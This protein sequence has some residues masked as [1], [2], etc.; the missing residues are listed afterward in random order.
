MIELRGGW[1]CVRERIYLYRNYNQMFDK[2]KTMIVQ[3]FILCLVEIAV[4]PIQ[5]HHSEHVNDPQ[6]LYA[7][8]A[9]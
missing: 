9:E 3:T 5:P 6:T 4:C 1:T 2:Y 8:H 7:S